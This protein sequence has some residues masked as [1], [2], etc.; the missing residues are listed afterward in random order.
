M[1]TCVVVGLSFGLRLLHLRSVSFRH[2]DA[3]VAEPRRARDL[4]RN[5]EVLLDASRCAKQELRLLACWGGGHHTEDVRS[6]CTS[7]HLDN[8]CSVMS[9]C[10]HTMNADAQDAK[11]E[12]RIGATCDVVQ[13]RLTTVL[14][15]ESSVLVF[16]V[17]VEIEVEVGSVSVQHL[18]PV[19]SV[20][21]FDALVPG[22]GIGAVLQPVPVPADHARTPRQL[23]VQHLLNKPVHSIYGQL[24]SE[25]WQKTPSNLRNN[26]QCERT[27]SCMEVWAS[28]VDSRHW[29]R[30]LGG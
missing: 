23:Q 19:E 25:V 30:K 15:P 11:K 4:H 24:F 22:L 9:C 14:N 5:L 29:Q 13:H 2:D 27:L 16:T 26:F 17:R 1:R 20:A 6:A 10:R 7:V 28:C 12:K 8:F 18:T 21:D 3:V